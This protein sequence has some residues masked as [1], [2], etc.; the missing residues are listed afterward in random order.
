MPEAKRKPRDR[1]RKKRSGK[2]VFDGRPTLTLNR[3]W[4]PKPYIDPVHDVFVAVK[5]DVPFN[6]A[7]DQVALLYA[8]AI[9]RNKLAEHA[10]KWLANQY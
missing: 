4:L 6:R 5:A 8:D 2:S 1:Y 3:Y 10:L 7:V 9:D